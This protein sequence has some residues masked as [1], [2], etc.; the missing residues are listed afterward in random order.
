MYLSLLTNE[1]S[2]YI[3]KPAYIEHMSLQLSCMVHGCMQV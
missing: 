2:S 3:T 1:E